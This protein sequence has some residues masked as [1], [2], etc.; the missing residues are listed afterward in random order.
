MVKGCWAE[1]LP[2]GPCTHMVYTWALKGLLYHDL[3][4]HVGTIVVLGRFGT[5][6]SRSI[7]GSDSTDSSQYSG[8][9]EPRSPNQSA[10]DSVKTRASNKEGM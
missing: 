5:I 9:Q 1:S 6:P 2:K 8:V 10:W 3:G 4:T 7:S